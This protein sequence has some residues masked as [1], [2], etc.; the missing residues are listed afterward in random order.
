MLRIGFG[1]DVHKF[2]PPASDRRL[3]LAGVDIPHECGLEGHSDA[4]VVAHAIM[5]A[6][7]G[8]AA[9][10]DIG[11]HFPPRDPQFKDADSMELLKKVVTLIA[12][13]KPWNI[14]VTAVAEQPRLSSHILQMRQNI[15]HVCE[16]SIENISV[17]ATTEEGLGLAGEGI[18][19]H[20]VCTIIQAQ[21]VVAL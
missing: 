7:L 4:D 8:A 1:Y 17:K 3:I 2:A 13:Y 15:A 11:Q 21:R 5:D 9:L 12:P 14:D 18:G 19:A 16:T 6:L 10:G 20:C